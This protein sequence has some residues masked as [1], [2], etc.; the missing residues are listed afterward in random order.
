MSIKE[1]DYTKQAQL[2]AKRMTKGL[3]TL[4]EAI[5]T[6]QKDAK[7]LLKLL[8]DSRRLLNFVA[9]ILTTGEIH[10]LPKSATEADKRPAPIVFREEDPS[11]DFGNWWYEKTSRVHARL[12]ELVDLLDRPDSETRQESIRLNVDETEMLLK[13]I[14]QLLGED[15]RIREVKAEEE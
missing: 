8:A 14:L 4:K 2:Y 5:L 12:F 15:L 7:T 11:R 6:G 1:T 10:G 3:A 13:S 9:P